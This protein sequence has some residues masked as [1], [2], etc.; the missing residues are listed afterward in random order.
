[1]LRRTFA[2]RG[3]NDFAVACRQVV[4][5]A[6]GGRSRA[7]LLDSAGAVIFEVDGRGRAT[8]R[9]AVVE[10]ALPANEVDDGWYRTEAALV[11]VH[12]GRVFSIVV[13][14]MLAVASLERLPEGAQPIP[15]AEIGALQLA[16]AELIEVF[17][18]GSE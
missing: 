2:G 1:M 13:A 18:Q 16:A 5:A 10:E 12:L 3:G 17:C 14:G 15:M 4:A 7:Q 6:I 8:E 9:P 11:V